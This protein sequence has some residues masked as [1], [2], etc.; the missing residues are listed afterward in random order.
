MGVKPVGE[1]SEKKSLR[2]KVNR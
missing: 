1:R 2:A